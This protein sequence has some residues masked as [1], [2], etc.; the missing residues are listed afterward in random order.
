MVKR[1]AMRLLA[2]FLAAFTLLAG[3]A[4]A[5]AQTP[6]GSTLRGYW[7]GIDDGEPAGAGD[8]AITRL[9]VEIRQR[10][11]MVDT[12]VE[13]ELSH[14][15]QQNDDPIEARLSL[16]LPQQAVVTGYELDIGGVMVAG[17]LLD[18]PKA[19]RVYEAE[20]RKGID[21]GLAE[22]SGN[23]FSTRVFPIAQGKSRTIRVHF[24]APIDALAG[25]VLPWPDVPVTG[26]VTVR[27]A[28]TAIDGQPQLSLP[29]GQPLA[30]KSVGNTW[31]AEASVPAV[32]V[33]GG[34]LAIRNVRLPRKLVVAE[35]ANG[36]AFFELGSE[37]ADTV[38]KTPAPPGRLRIYWDRSWS[39]S[40]DALD[41]E[42]ALLDAYLE[43]RPVSG[44][45]LV[46]F[47]E[48]TPVV[49]S[50][51]SAADLR[52][53][54]AGQSYLGATRLAGLDALR[55]AD[56][57]QCLLFT[58]G[59]R[60]LDP[61]AEFAPDCRL[62]IIASAPDADI[63]YLGN[64]AQ[65]SGGRLL[66]LGADNKSAV[67]AALLNPGPGVVRVRSA[68]GRRVPFRALATTGGGWHI[69]GPMRGEEGLSLWI[70]DAGGRVTIE[71]FDVE[72]AGRERHDGAAALWA[73][74]EVARLAD[75]PADHEA[76]VE[77]ARKFQVASASLAFLVLESPGQYVD[78]DVA[79]PAGG[80]DDTWREEYRELKKEKD[81]AAQEQRAGHLAMVRE[82][83]ASRK[84]WWATRFNPDSRA[85]K[86]QDDEGADAAAAFAPPPPPA[87]P[88]PPAS[89]DALSELPGV[90]DYT[91]ATEPAGSGYLEGEAGEVVV[92]AQRRAERTQDVPLAI[93][94]LSGSAMADSKVEISD[95]LSDGPYIKALDAAAPAARETV[96]REQAKQ[97]GSLAGFWLDVAEWYRVKGDG[98][99]A[100][101]LL[102]TALDAPTADDETRQIVAFRLERDGRIDDA[103]A[104]LE[105]LAALNAE[106]PQPKRLLA[107]ALAKRGRP[108]DLERAFALL[109]EVALEPFPNAFEG[110]DTIALMEANALVPALD[111]AGIAWKL[112]PEFV[113]LLDTDVRL[114]IEW[115]ND[116]ADI[117]LWVIEP[118]GERVYYANALSAAGGTI[119]NDMTDGY[120]PE[121]Y[122]IR[123]ARGGDY[124]VR[125]HGYSP[126]RINPNGTG[127]VT[128]RLIRDFGRVSQKEQLVDAEIGFGKDEEQGDG[129]RGI[130]TLTV[131][132]RR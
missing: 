13:A 11:G 127:R 129:S 130:A 71:R 119:S 101:R 77:L 78:A 58:D 27:Y 128:V 113:A 16:L 6:A 62:S 68:S 53:A 37:P 34:T 123:R 70:A 107:L 48:D 95:L 56:A 126:D 75:D 18:Q 30:A 103:I 32:A 116:D 96:L 50:V 60:T 97:Y 23:R 109:T 84:Q 125:I 7:N 92:T 88:P 112:D 106:R 76:M 52:A 67:L 80:F 122:V 39:R 86:D 115:T 28:G 14:R 98:P 69:V 29:W 117:D 31:K 108:A 79:P 73:A 8:L 63:T 49:T 24:S 81:D 61:A 22:V 94:A 121:E 51:A 21:P 38:A 102:L 10:G 131:P 110:I 85:K 59:A 54:L 90:V 1:P 42:M 41:A 5:A 25:F 35:H 89:A 99:T 12:S 2:F 104:I 111:R 65:D 105:R 87:A 57:A 114:V 45:D 91:A 15:S 46:S 20:V 124:R 64:L 40:D 43:A 83:W 74:G 66:Q 93:S 132:S 26:P 72:G 118:N 82:N 19:R 100:T 47:A 17:T 4:S 33:A 3:P 9:T 120:G 55:L 44:I 36:Q